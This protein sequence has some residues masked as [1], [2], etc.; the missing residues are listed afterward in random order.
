MTYS[1]RVI[2]CLT[3]IKVMDRVR[4]ARMKKFK[5]DDSDTL[6]SNLLSV[7]PGPTCQLVDSHP[8]LHPRPFPHKAL[9]I[10]NSYAATLCSQHH[11]SLPH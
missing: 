5:L 9:I 2:F 7:E 4:C 8:E 3:I 1:Q 6:A 10:P 11:R